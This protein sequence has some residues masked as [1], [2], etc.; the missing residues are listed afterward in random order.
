FVPLPATWEVFHQ[1]G[2]EV[3]GDLAERFPQEILCKHLL[4]NFGFRGVDRQDAILILIP[5]G[6]GSVSHFGSASFN[7]N[8]HFNRKNSSVL[9]MGTIFSTSWSNSSMSN[10]QGISGRSASVSC[11]S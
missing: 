3:G 4:H 7:S 6:N 5:E 9:L 8:P 10:S 2:G 11:N 1:F